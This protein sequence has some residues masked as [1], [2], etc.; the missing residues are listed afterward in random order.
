LHHSIDAQVWPEV[1]T[2]SA[3][4][5]IDWDDLRIFLALFRGQS[6]RA[7]SALLGISHSTVSR[8]LN[9]L[10]TKLDSKLFIRRADGLI[11]TET[12]EAILDRAERVE[13]EVLSLEREVSG[14]DSKLSGPIRLTAPPPL[15]HSLL[16]PHI[17]EFADFHPGIQ[18]EMV[19][20]YDVADLA[21]RNADVAIRFQ[22]KP[23][24][25]LVGRRLPEFRNA[26]Y[27]TPEYI[28]KHSF[29]GPKPTA[30]WIGWGESK[31][32]PKWKN[33]TELSK[34]KIG[35]L[36]SD[37]VGQ[38]AAAAAGL[39]MSYSLCFLGDCI[40]ELVRVQ[41][42]NTYPERPA[43]VLTHPD[44]ITSERVRIFM[45]FIVKALSLHQTDLSGTQEQHSNSGA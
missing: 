5:D 31:I 27:A 36:A 40:P 42:N 7:A 39:G 20:S 24:A 33:A 37:P 21:K 26:V 34:C 22:E 13:R 10:E 19:A 4:A 41:P 35:H 17:A 43:W 28:A 29:T 2:G 1:L 3:M 44:L 18:I 12:S 30:R 9:G 32:Q 38:L 6:V 8:R 45:R 23:D 14:R 15:V 25:F 11:A 16:A